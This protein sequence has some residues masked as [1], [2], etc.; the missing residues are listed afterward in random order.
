MT[1]SAHPAAALTLIVALG[2]ITV[3]GCSSVPEKQI[4]EAQEAAEN[5]KAARVELYAPELMEQALAALAAAEADIAAQD[6]K[7]IVL[8]N[9]KGATLKLA[10]AMEAFT[11]ATA[12]A[13]NQKAQLKGPV[14]S[15][16]REASLMVDAVEQEVAKLTARRAAAD[17]VALQDQVAGLRQG[18]AD[19][20][21]A[22][23]AADYK[24]AK[25]TLE[26]VLAEATELR[27]KLDPN[28]VMEAP[29]P[30]EPEAAAPKAPAAPPPA[31]ADTAKAD[32]AA[33]T[34]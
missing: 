6:E 24:G 1:S 33:K 31:A 14:R 10:E 30:A 19:A 5:A 18:L 4:A 23:K 29:P 22:E 3:A 17:V 26:S 20:S 16:V 21:A 2:A 8:R 28:W 34:G 12:E 13:T 7:F 11:Q 32:S 9:Y 27:T 15:L 25:S